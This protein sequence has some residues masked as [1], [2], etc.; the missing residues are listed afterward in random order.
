MNDALSALQ[1]LGVTVGFGLYAWPTPSGILIE[2]DPSIMSAS[3]DDKYQWDVELTAIGNPVTSYSFEV[4]PG[5]IAAMLPSN[6]FDTFNVSASGTFYIIATC[7]TDGKAVTSSVLSV[8]S[9][10]PALPAPQIGAGASSL[11][12]VIGV[13]VDG[14]YFNAWKKNISVATREV[15]REDKPSPGPLEL[16]YISWWGWS[17]S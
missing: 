16:P 7:T 9:A 4:W 14:T 5:L 3:L 13:F 10:P 2:I 1:A 12:F 8:E 17:V 15:I 6:M 11:G